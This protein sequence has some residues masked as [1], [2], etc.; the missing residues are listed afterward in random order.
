MEHPDL[1]ALN[2]AIE[3]SKKW[4]ETVQAM[5]D[6]HQF[7]S[8]AR[9]RLSITLHHLSIE[10]HSAIHTLVDLHVWGSAFALLRPQLESYVRGMWYGACANND[11][12]L[13]F[14]QDKEPPPFKTLITQL[15]EA[16]AVDGTLMR[17]HQ[18]SWRELCGFTHGGIAQIKNRITRDE[19]VSRYELADVTKLVGG[20]AV[21]VLSACAGISRV[22]DDATL[23][24]KATKAYDAIYGTAIAEKFPE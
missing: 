18:K 21:L 19:I 17:I 13:G 12:I 20:S 6:G 4:M 16:D 2:D 1:P 24:V 7:D 3:K 5:T 8:T 15:E 9:R 14:Y 11:E 23:A 22:I 10:H